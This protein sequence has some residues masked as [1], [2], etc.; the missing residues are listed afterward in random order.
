MNAEQVE[1]EDGVRLSVPF[2]SN[3]LSLSANS[4]LSLGVGRWC[5]AREAWEGLLRVVSWWAAQEIWRWSKVACTVEPEYVIT[6]NRLFRGRGR[7]LPFPEIVVSG[8]LG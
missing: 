4:R 8:Y 2:S 6:T 7:T 3:P 5:A 1:E